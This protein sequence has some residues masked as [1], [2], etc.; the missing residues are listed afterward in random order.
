MTAPQTV[1][2]V[3]V[4]RLLRVEQYRDVIHPVSKNS[5]SVRDKSWAGLINYRAVRVLT[6]KK[7]FKTNRPE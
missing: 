2:S 5:I 4:L 7:M 6:G 3:L 1:Y